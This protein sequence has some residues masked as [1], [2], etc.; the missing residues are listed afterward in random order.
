MR[1][2][3]RL[4]DR[5]MRMKKAR[6]LLLEGY[7]LE[8]IIKI[9]RI[10]ENTLMDNFRENENYLKGIFFK[11]TRSISKRMEHLSIKEVQWDLKKKS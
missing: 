4:E 2:D 8:R 10:S 9:L 5:D 1:Y 11:K 7:T 3:S 6:K